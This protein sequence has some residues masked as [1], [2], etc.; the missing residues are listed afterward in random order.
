MGEQAGID[1]Y[2]M[3][4]QSM[5]AQLGSGGK[6]DPLSGLD[7]IT[8][9]LKNK[10]IVREAEVKAEKLELKKA[11]NKAGEKIS[12]AF[13]EM[14]PTLKSLGP[15]SFNQCQQ[16]VKAIREQMFRAI[17]AKDQDAIAKLNMQL[18]E[19][20][21]KHSADA[22]N[23]TNLVDSYESELVSSDAM[24]N[25]HQVIHEQFATNPTK[26][27]VYH[28]GVLHYEWEHPTK[29]NDDGSPFIES[30]TME[31]LNDMLVFK[32]TEN[33]VVMIDKVQAYKEQVKENP[34]SMP[35]DA[36]LLSDMKSIIPKDPKKLRDWLHGNPAEADG[37]D[38]E[39]YLH[40]L[41]SFENNNAT[42]AVQQISGDPNF[43]N[44]I[45]NTSGPNGQIDDVVDIHDL[46]PDDINNLIN[47]IMDVEDP[48]KSHEIIS[49]IYADISK[50]NIL[51]LSEEEGGN[52]DYRSH[53]ETT[54]M[55]NQN[56][57]DGLREEERAEKLGNLQSLSDPKNEI[58][59]DL[60][61][62]NALEIAKKLG[63]KDLNAQILVDGKM[64]SIRT[65]IPDAGKAATQGQS[66]G[67]DRSKKKD[68]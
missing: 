33:G 37:L 25:E 4:K 51:G 41:L 9:T 2:K 19:L 26:K 13:V 60:E 30:H 28:D 8:R 31:S 46:T 11:R 29:K 56:N 16:E 43:F 63:F 7:Q 52:K 34:D 62:L 18:N 40:D 66:G 12:N 27:A 57:P 14:G 17:D 15:E 44:N 32:D 21:A 24:T 5:Q 53:T 65:F 10:Q 68:A 42:L 61:G 36:K 55:G 49:E 38:V 3:G 67:T 64:T 45:K 6:D 39:Q 48:E 23:L 47:K 22:E 59:D 58:W 35:T 20:K 54:I 1:W 50:N